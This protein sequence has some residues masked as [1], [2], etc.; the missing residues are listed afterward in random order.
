MTSAISMVGKAVRQR[1]RLHSQPA[2]GMT[3]A[4]RPTCTRPT[5][6][7][8]GETLLHV[9][10]WLMGNVQRPTSNGTFG[11]TVHPLLHPVSYPLGDRQ[12]TAEDDANTRRKDEQLFPRNGRNTA[13]ILDA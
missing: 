12:S 3:K 11:R 1:P 5:P 8:A 7:Q 2:L 13:P 9:V 6:R 10:C 4:D